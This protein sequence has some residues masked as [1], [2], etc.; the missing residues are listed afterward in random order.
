MALDPHPIRVAAIPAPDSPPPAGAP[1]RARRRG[2]G[3]LPALAALCLLLPAPAG[4]RDDPFAGAEFLDRASAIRAVL[5]RNPGARAALHAWEAAR[6]QVPQATSLPDP[7]V[8]Y[9]FAPLSAGSDDAPFGHRVQVRQRFPAPGRLRL[10][11][12]VAAGEAEAARDELEGVR[13]DLALEAASLVDAL[14]AVARGIEVNAEHRALLAD[15]QAVATARFA[16]GQASMQDPL[17]AEVEAAHVEH[18]DVALAA[19]REALRARL[20]ALLHRAPGAPL[21]EPPRDLPSPDAAPLPGP[22]ELEAL[23]LASRPE[24]QAARDRASAAEA[25]VALARREWLPD[26]GAMASYDTMA[27]HDVHRWM[28]GVELNLPLGIS[29]RRAA[30]EQARARL[31]GARSEA[32]RVLD[33][34][35]SDVHQALARLRAARHVEVLFRDRLIP[36][37]RDQVA[38]ARSGFETGR[39]DFEALVGAER[40]L[41]AAE[42]SLAEAQAEVS[43]RHAELARSVGRIP[44]EIVPPGEEHP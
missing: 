14:Y 24:V 35:R 34:V 12:A 25:A 1:P 22:E 31:A 23:A 8:E 10:G 33:E 4:A 9:G 7:T 18:D 41:R 5:D 40:A 11:G 17:R 2:P 30:L 32:E 13:L 36:A 28:V 37:A 3:L 39:N 21:P 29:R 20:N 15:L 19:R 27:M 42:R 44:G 16:A 6:A 43:T 38:A 26:V